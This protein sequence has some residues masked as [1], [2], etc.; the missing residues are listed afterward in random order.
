MKHA[1]NKPKESPTGVATVPHSWPSSR[2]PDSVYPNT[3][4]KARYLVRVHRRELLECGALARIERDLVVIGAN[5]LKWL[6][7][8]RAH[9]LGYEIAPNRPSE[10]EEG[11]EPR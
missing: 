10:G 3:Q 11:A 1:S 7:Q 2:W 8:H 9:V 5:Y 6:N 4:E